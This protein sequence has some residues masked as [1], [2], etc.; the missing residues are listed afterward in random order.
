MNR[1]YGP[2]EASPKDVRE[3][4]T[5]A[6]ALPPGDPGYRPAWD[7]VY[8][9]EASMHRSARRHRARERQA[10]MPAPL[11]LFDRAEIGTEAGL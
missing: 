5:A 4:F 6:E 3:A 7:R 8:A 10:G 9:T 11:P 1:S 2:R